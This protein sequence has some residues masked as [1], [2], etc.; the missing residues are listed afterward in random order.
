MHEM[1]YLETWLLL[2]TIRKTKID[3]C[4]L[5]QNNLSITVHLRIKKDCE[6]K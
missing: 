5:Y 2:S 3:I 1:N 6:G 4:I